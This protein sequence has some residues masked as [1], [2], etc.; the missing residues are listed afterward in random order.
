MTDSTE[1]AASLTGGITDGIT[2]ACGTDRAPRNLI[3][4][5]VLDEPGSEGYRFLERMLVSSLLRTFFTG[6]IVVF[7]NTENPLFLV[8]RKGLEEVYVETPLI[9]GREGWDTAMSWKYKVAEMLDVQGYDKVLFLDS[10]FLALRNIDH[11]LAGDWDIAY[12]VQ[13]GETGDG[14]MFNG[15]YDEEE[16]AV[17]RPHSGVNA[18]SYAVRAA[19][20]HDV[21]RE[22]QRIDEGAMVRPE[23]GFR[24]Q[25]SWNAL[26]MRRT[27]WLEG[28][29]EKRE[30]GRGQDVPATWRAVPFPEKEIQF[31][32]YLDPHYKS[33]SQAALSHNCGGNTLEKIQFTF[34]LYMRTF[35]CDPTGLF[36]QMLEM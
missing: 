16:M 25:A 20:F 2:V 24:D 36:F 29:N 3:Y 17:A 13:R 33:Y 26:M 28:G 15:F 5:L 10:D 34:G 27:D 23:S 32:M 35:Y 22:W 11:L 18:G 9:V 19:I 21:M 31:P 12:Q 14:W 7:R 30:G 1:A 6:D 4:T 8:E